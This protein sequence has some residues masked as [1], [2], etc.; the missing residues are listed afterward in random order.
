MAQPDFRGARGSNAGDDFHEIW[1]LRQALSLLE[2]GSALAAIS[3]EGLRVE[4]E[5]GVVSDT[6]DGVDCALYYGGTTKETA[7]RIEIVQVKYSAAN[8]EKPWT[9]A[10][11]TAKT[12]KRADSSV[13]GRLAKAYKG[14]RTGD[15]NSGLSIGLRLITNRPVADNVRNILSNI[16][17]SDSAPDKDILEDIQR[18]A[19]ASALSSQELRQFAERLDLSGQTG[20]RFAV[21][22][23]VVR[24][25][26]AWTDDDARAMVNDLVRFISKKMT[27]ESKGE[28][29]TQQ[30]I[31]AQLGFSDS[32]GLFP[33]PS[34]IPRV[35]KL[36][37]REVAQEVVQKLLPVKQ[38]ICLHGQGGCG[39]TTVLQDIEARLPN[40]SVMIVFDC[41]GAGRYRD[42]DAFRHRPQDAFLQLSNELA[43]RLKVPLLLTSGRG[44][45][46]RS[47]KYRIDK[48][49]AALRGA[50]SEALLVIV[51]DA[52]DNSTAA[53]ESCSPPEHSFIHD[54]IRLGQLPSNARLVVTA[55]SGRLKALNLPS[56]FEQ[57]EVPSFTRNETAAFVR[58]VWPQASD[59]WIDD[60]DYLSQ[61]NPRVQRYALENAGETKRRAL[62]YLKPGGKGLQDVFAERMNLAFKKGGKNEEL[63]K[64]CA[65][66]IA[67][68]RPIP[69]EDLSAIAVLTPDEIRDIC[70]DLAPGLPI[71]EDEVSFADEDFERFV[72]AQGT[73]QMVE[74]R[75]SIAEWFKGR[76][77]TNQYAAVHVAGALFDAGMRAEILDLVK[78]EADL[79]TVVDPI[80][81]R[82]ARLR[83]LR[84]AMRVCGQDKNVVG[85][86]QT[87]LIGAEA[88][89]TDAMIR[90]L[91]V[92][93]P[94]VAATFMRESAAKL[95]LRDPGRIEHHGSLLFQIMLSNAREGKFVAARNDQRQ[96]SAWL[97]RRQEDLS[98]KRS[99][100]PE[101]SYVDAWE[102][103]DSDIAAETEATLLMWG[104]AAAYSYLRRWTP[105]QVALRVAKLVVPR[106]ITK[107]Q[108]A[109]LEQ[110]LQHRA[111]PIAW[112]AI[113]QVDL[114]IAGHEIDLGELEDSLLA[115]HRRKLLRPETIQN[116]WSQGTSDYL[117][118][119]AIAGCEIIISRGR[120]LSRVLPI[121]N[122]F[123]AED[124]R[125]LD[126][127]S[128]S[129][130]ALLDI[131]L[132]AHA[133]LMLA[134]QEEISLSSFLVE[135]PKSAESETSDGKRDSED[136]RQKKNIIGPLIH[137][138]AARAKIIVDRLPN[139]AAIALLK[140]ASE[141]YEAQKY[142]LV[143]EMGSWQM[144]RRTAISLAMLLCVPGLDPTVI[145]ESA[146]RMFAP[147][148]LNPEDVDML[149]VFA[150]RKA[151]QNS[152]LKIIATRSKEIEKQKTVAQDKIDILLALSR[153][154]LPMSSQDSQALFELAH[155][156]TEELDTD[157]VFHLRTLAG[158]A[159]RCSTA[160]PGD[161]RRLLSTRFHIVVTDA[162][163]R[164]SEQKGFP[165]SHV[166]SGLSALDVAMA[167]ASVARWEDAGLIGRETTLQSV[168]QTAL[169][170]GS[171]TSA[172]TIALL[173]L[174][175]SVDSSLIRA[176]VD[177]ISDDLNSGSNSVLDVLAKDK[178]LG[179]SGQAAQDELGTLADCSTSAGSPWIDALVRTADFLSVRKESRKQDVEKERESSF[180]KTENQLNISVDTSFVTS[181]EIVEEIRKQKD[182]AEEEGRSVRPIDLFNRLR[183]Q[184][185]V[186]NRVQHLEALIRSATDESAYDV[187][188][189][190]LAAINDWRESSLS[191]E[192]WCHDRLPEVFVELFMGFAQYLPF[193]EEP[194]ASVLDVWAS[195]PETIRRIVLEAIERNVEHLGAASIYELVRIVTRYVAPEDAG[196][197]LE[198][199]LGR[200]VQRIPS[201]E[202]DIVDE[203]D[204]PNEPAKAVARF[205]FALMSDV[206]LR[207]RWRA[208]HSV[209][210]LADFGEQQFIDALFSIYSLQTEGAYRQ[211][212]T[213]FYWM[214]A[215]LWFLMAVDRITLD[216][217]EIV[218]K[219]GR[220]LFEVATDSTFPHVL[221][222]S[223]A[224]DAVLKL[225]RR[226]CFSLT[227]AERRILKTADTS[228]LKPRSRR[229]SSGS[230]DV[231]MEKWQSRYNFDSM[232]TLPYWYDPAIRKFAN[233]GRKEFLE[234]AE[235]WVLDRWKL[236]PD[237]GHWQNE[238]RKHRFPER[239]WGL[240]SHDHGSSPILERFS[241]YVE[242][243]AMFCAVGELLKS[244]ALDKGDLWDTFENWLRREKLS[245][246]PYWLSDLRT[247]RPLSSRL[248]FVPEGSIAQWIDN[249]TDEEFFREVEFEADS[250]TIVVGA[251]HETGCSS[252][253]FEARVRSALVQPDTA[254]ALVRALQTMEDSWDYKLPDP[255]ESFEIDD[256]PYRLLG[257]LSRSDLELRIDERDP[258][259]A[260]VR[261]VSS[262]PKE[263]VDG[264]LE[265]RVQS[266]GSVA[267]FRPNGSKSFTYQSWSDGR[268]ESD[269]GYR[270]SGT[271]GSEGWI[272]R[273]FKNNLRDYLCKSGLDLILEIELT[274][275]DQDYGYRGLSKKEPNQ[276]RY[277]KVIILRKDGAVET[278]EGRI[279]AW[280]VPG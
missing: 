166:S 237:L 245:A 52:A 85:A 83:R 19:G 168:L 133:L 8:P 214:A 59:P 32:R 75:K 216:N 60:F 58:S 176:T 211:A 173:A 104:P 175:E 132:R 207:T 72:E 53:A 182:L 248:W 241:T 144:R 148:P 109:L 121:L 98:D 107:G 222:R 191:V 50:N 20:S 254:L 128:M 155:R 161:Q 92:Q 43:T 218:A 76:S 184:V 74:I 169:Q 231:G 227:A 258:F 42:A 146:Q 204:L 88:T 124:L 192:R 188:K 264:P 265:K 269:D 221:I 69:L 126:R 163:I 131:Q 142:Q 22:E 250:P 1:V 260:G 220:Q 14:I 246:P 114:A 66:V 102:I 263:G 73:P 187:A 195:E 44:D 35:D 94:D 210:R 125:T 45:Y 217:S 135:A 275:R 213:P 280:Y 206:D 24:T 140:S 30:S 130:A 101:G 5:K 199:Q 239:S 194:V 63:I 15:S 78:R 274:K 96:L 21:E 243:H 118:Q 255:G 17:K 84:L 247:A 79:D 137:V 251:Y 160:V 112:R 16:A 143:H 268:I 28:F 267:W 55:R 38:Y 205:L 77:Q 230:S 249:I 103:N 150:S 97:R 229:T 271:I 209:R 159:E 12:S 4:D 18:I 236:S 108:S 116:T 186:G 27:P 25:I 145:L 278:A 3:V 65:A 117:P 198:W 262:E 147:G 61:H 208:A 11:L 279:G 200:L 242:W 170:K 272:L 115:L 10:D 127:V 139:E 152:V 70:A 123:A 68:P 81:R 189:A 171:L 13:I 110:L 179:F 259:R 164:L 111:L 223:F 232:D 162:A 202:K 225:C 56:N 62:D 138:Y 113:L 197:L 90:Q 177:R 190:V 39:K 82:D 201:G 203:N 80:R 141:S 95:I 36:V 51:A 244:Q 91:I 31:L 57:L 256:P 157:A 180:Y 215:R 240:W 273:M 6:W 40:N 87:V 252:F 129:K 156:I 174:V 266:D 48:A 257:W 185:G 165:W 37:L 105:R 224:K 93:N 64:F 234:C 193:D 99:R 153:L 67:L 158:L 89:K 212:D 9:L 276:A 181:S 136:D 33:C 238:R 228:R 7:E 49:A 196:R 233:V 270:S 151:A 226:N 235:I 47:F 34:Q 86:L 54:L 167:L 261:P 219:H 29:I 106:L 149:S 2:V 23:S 154:V 183:R 26:S 100:R 120:D 71:N 253:R 46:A 41:Y 122:A 172:Q 277:D 134:K 178:L 119:L